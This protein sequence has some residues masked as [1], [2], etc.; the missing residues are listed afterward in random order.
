MPFNKKGECRNTG[1]THFE[2]GHTPWHKGKVGVYSEDT[3]YRMGN[4]HRGKSSPMKG[5][6]HSLETR[7]K[8]RQTLVKLHFNEVKH[9][10]IQYQNNIWRELRK[11]VY[12]RDGW[13]CQ[14]CGKHSS[15]YRSLHAHHIDY[16]NTNNDLSNLITLCPS[17]HGK[18]LFK[19]FDWVSYYYKKVKLMPS[20]H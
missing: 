2:K 14:E 19:K 15:G 17:C 7:E 11:V 3:R 16:D 6:H 18:T 10:G 20:R 4:S 1:R 13:C 9:S 12:R 8:I 5:R